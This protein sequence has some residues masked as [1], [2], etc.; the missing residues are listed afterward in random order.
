M[1]APAGRSRFPCGSILKPTFAGSDFE[2][3]AGEY[4][5]TV[6]KAEFA[7]TRLPQLGSGVGLT[8]AADA[9][10]LF[11]T[12]FETFDLERGDDFYERPL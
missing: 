3:W 6:R 5:T 8:A 2:A 9:D 11:D 4:D 1:P 10:D 12:F 7:L